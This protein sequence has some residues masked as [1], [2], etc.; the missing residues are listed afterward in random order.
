MAVWSE[1]QWNTKNPKW[2]LCVCVCMNVSACEHLCMPTQS[3]IFPQHF[4][5]CYVSN[6]DSTT[7]KPLVKLI[8]HYCVHAWHSI[9]I[10]YRYVRLHSAFHSYEFKVDILNL[11]PFEISQNNNRKETEVAT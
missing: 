6:E 4:I 1:N 9:T 10:E 7:N 5:K 11:K 3:C 2:A 8:A